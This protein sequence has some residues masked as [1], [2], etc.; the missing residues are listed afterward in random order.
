MKPEIETWGEFM[1]ASIEERR[2]AMKEILAEWEM[3]R[4]REVA[5]DERRDGKRGHWGD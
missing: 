3:N 5:E 4:A 1:A 2:K